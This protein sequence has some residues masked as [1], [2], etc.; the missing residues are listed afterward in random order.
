MMIVI[1]L[2]LSE[3]DSFAIHVD[4]FRFLADNEPQGISEYFVKIEPHEIYDNDINK[5]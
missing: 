5:D 4:A 3:D 1:S 2:K